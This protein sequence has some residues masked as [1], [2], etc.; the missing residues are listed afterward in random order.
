[1][2]MKAHPPRRVAGIL[3]GALFGSIV[4]LSVICAVV[5]SSGLSHFFSTV[6]HQQLDRSHVIGDHAFGLCV[7]CFWLYA[8][9]S[10]GCLGFGCLNI[11]SRPSKSFLILSLFIVVIHWVGG[12]F[13]S[14]FDWVFLR[15]VSSLIL[16][17]A[18]SQYIVPGVSELLFSNAH[19]NSIVEFKHES[20]R[21]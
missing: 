3:T 16:G 4:L 2:I 10:L 8:G 19:S 7:R 14:S 12:W 9:L 13:F 15:V 21:T 6:C 11:Q 1:M 20:K 5:T 17:F 18:L